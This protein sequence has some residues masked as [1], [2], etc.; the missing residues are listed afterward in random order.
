MKRITLLLIAV[1]IISLT[2]IAQD[3]ITIDP[4]PNVPV[5]P[6]H[7]FDC[8]S[9]PDALYYV[10][11]NCVNPVIWD[12]QGMRKL[13]TWAFFKETAGATTTDSGL[14]VGFVWNWQTQAY[15]YLLL[16]RQHDATIGYAGQYKIIADSRITYP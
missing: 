3:I 12:I 2:A 7:S 4:I 1:L 11:P 15:D 14:V 13:G 9:N 16:T 10:G 6:G 8:Q 5:P